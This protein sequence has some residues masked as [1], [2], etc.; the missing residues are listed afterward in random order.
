MTATCGLTTMRDAMA[1]PSLWLIIPPT[2]KAFSGIVARK[3]FVLR[4]VLS[5]S[6][7][8]RRATLRPQ[9][10]FEQLWR[11]FPQMQMPAPALQLR[12]GVLGV[13]M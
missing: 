8:Q 6:M 11:L 3:M 2:G 12:F 10:D 13:G 7:S 4:V 5:Q 1:I 9:R